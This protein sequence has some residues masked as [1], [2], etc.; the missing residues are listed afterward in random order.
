MKSKKVILFLFIISFLIGKTTAQPG[1]HVS[2]N[3]TVIFGFDTANQG[4]KLMWIPTKGAF[5][6][7]YAEGTKWDYDSL[8]SNSVAFGS[9]TKATGFGSAVFGQLS[10]ATGQSSVAFGNSTR[11][12][13][14]TTATFGAATT[15]TGSTAA[16]FGSGTRADARYCMAIG[17]ANV[18]GGN[19]NAWISTDPI[20]EVGIGQS[21]RR[22]AFTVYKN[23]RCSVGTPGSNNVLLTLNSERSWNFYQYG[24]GANTA[25]K[26]SG[27]SSSN[28]NKNFLID[29][30]GNI[31]ISTNSPA[32]K[33]HVNGSAG[34]PG[35][36]SWSNA[37]DRRLK[38]RI[39]NFT[40][41]M[42]IIKHL[43]PVSFEYNGKL[44]LPVDTRYVGV[45][46]QELENIAPFMVS[47]FVAEDGEIYLNVDP[48]AFD[49]LL[50]NAIKQ[51]Q[52]S[53]DDLQKIL[54]DQRTLTARQEILMQ[55]IQDENSVLRVQLSELKEEIKSMQ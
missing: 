17:R 37:S 51:Q 45:I 8:G 28:N 32:Y 16:A 12:Q 47:P 40:S 10:E 34:K 19:P 54:D 18:G 9:Q 44:N 13:G 25:L 53:L 55:Q 22:N 38:T 30:E 23:G 14:F 50:I 11:S 21:T 7:G 48:S 24:S 1:L 27:S 41:G 26:L 43:R 20:F 15:A 31:G 3:Q 2:Q 39:T 4:T 46:A 49:F 35:G 36:G 6:A 52:K 29:T 5:R 42:E 33:L